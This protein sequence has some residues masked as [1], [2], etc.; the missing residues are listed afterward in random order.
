[1]MNLSFMFKVQFEYDTFGNY[2]MFPYRD[3]EKFKEHDF[4][5]SREEICVMEL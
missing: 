3:E 1:M 5:K 2:A 4:Y